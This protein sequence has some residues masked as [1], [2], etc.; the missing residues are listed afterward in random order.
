ME[1]QAVP[2]TLQEALQ[3]EARH[4]MV[5]D[6][7]RVN[8]EEATAFVEPPAATATAAAAQIGSGSWQPVLPG[9]TATLP[10]YPVP[11]CRITPGLD[12]QER[13]RHEMGRCTRPVQ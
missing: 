9:S 12:G 1:C 11:A 7:C 5:H 8:V 6:G 2:V 10:R 4:R 13:A 3:G